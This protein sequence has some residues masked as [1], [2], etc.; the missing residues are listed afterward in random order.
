MI[1]N[2]LNWMLCYISNA[3][4]QFVYGLQPKKHNIT[5]FKCDN[6]HNKSQ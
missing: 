3:T 4:V 2:D 5:I 6:Y 1:F